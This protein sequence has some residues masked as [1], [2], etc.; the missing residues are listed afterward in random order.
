[1]SPLPNSGQWRRGRSP[2]VTEPPAFAL[3][4]IRVQPATTITWFQAQEA[5]AASG[6]R[7]PTREEWLRAANG[8]PDDGP[9]NG[10]MGTCITNRT[11]GPA[12]RDTTVDGTCR[13][14]WGAYDMIGNVAEWTDEWYASTGTASSG[15]FPEG[16]WPGDTFHS[17]RVWNVG[18][19]VAG[20]YPSTAW[21]NLPA[22][23]Q[24]GGDW[25]SRNATGVFAMLLNYAPSAADNAS[26]F[27]CV[28]PR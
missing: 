26:G 6:K 9:T 7:L 1:M 10:E 19:Y 4:R 16:T 27:R 3:S 23:V 20:S 24:R 2:Y 11:T 18:S 15:G 12:P 8:T 21:V 13:S 5:C 17:D 28:I 22:A 25:G 14:G